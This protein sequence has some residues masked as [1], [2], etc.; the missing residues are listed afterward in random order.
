MYKRQEFIKLPARS[1]VRSHN[2]EQGVTASRVRKN[3][4]A[5]DGVDALGNEHVNDEEAWD[6]L[7]TAS[8]DGSVICTYLGK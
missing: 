1:T 7:A 6:M 2:T 4:W 5:F 8:E 3:R